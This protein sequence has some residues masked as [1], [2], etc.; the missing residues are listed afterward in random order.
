[1]RVKVH[2]VPPVGTAS[3]PRRPRELQGGMGG[4]A[5]RGENGYGLHSTDTGSHEVKPYVLPNTQV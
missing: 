5:I 1:M 4:D 3:P 2:A